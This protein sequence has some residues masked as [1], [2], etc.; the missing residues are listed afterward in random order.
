MVKKNY[1]AP[2]FSEIYY[3]TDVIMESPPEEGAAQ[4]N[5]EWN[6]YDR[7]NKGGKI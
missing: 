3:T 2:D 4:W 6:D 1:L 5:T 7:L